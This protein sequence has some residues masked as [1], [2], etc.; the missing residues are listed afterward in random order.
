MVNVEND[1]FDEHGA[2]I[3]WVKGGPGI[4]SGGTPSDQSRGPLKPGGECFAP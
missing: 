4:Q 3:S 1:S 2:E